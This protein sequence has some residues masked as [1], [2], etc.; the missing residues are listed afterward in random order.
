MDRSIKDLYDVK[1]VGMQSLFRAETHEYKFMSVLDTKD[2]EIE[3]LQ[4][5]NEVDRMYRVFL[6]CRILG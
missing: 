4:L 1:K 3:R 6:N 2:S 5:V